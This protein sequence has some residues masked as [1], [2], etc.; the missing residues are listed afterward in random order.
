VALDDVVD[1]LNGTVL[2]KA[3]ELIDEVGSS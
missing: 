1:P 2:C 3:G